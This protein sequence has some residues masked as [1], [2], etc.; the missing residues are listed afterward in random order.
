MMVHQQLS[1]LDRKCPRREDRVN[2]L[3]SDHLLR[4]E[5]TMVVYKKEW[6]DVNGLII[7]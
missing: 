3:I 1:Y 2:I 6:K 5:D 7:T 4:L